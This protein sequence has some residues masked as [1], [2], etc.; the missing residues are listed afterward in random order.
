[1]TPFMPFHSMLFYRSNK[2]I[3]HT[4]LEMFA[5]GGAR[6]RTLPPTIPPGQTCT[7]VCVGGEFITKEE[8][9]TMNR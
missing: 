7:Q 9:Y 2:I 5:Q 8:E 1:M 3:P 6:V 4:V